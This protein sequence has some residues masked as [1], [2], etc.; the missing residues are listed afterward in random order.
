MYYNILY[1]KS[2]GIFG[3]IYKTKNKLDQYIV[4]FSN[5]LLTNST[6]ID[7]QGFRNQYKII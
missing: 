4:P 3:R 2:L 6:E 5:F 1:I 7:S